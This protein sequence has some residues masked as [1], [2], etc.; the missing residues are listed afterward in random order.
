MLMPGPP[1]AGWVGEGGGSNGAALTRPTPNISGEM[2][3]PAAIAAALAARLRFIGFRFPRG[4]VD[5]AGQRL[6]R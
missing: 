2:A 6:P 5:L 4:F 3:T 1:G